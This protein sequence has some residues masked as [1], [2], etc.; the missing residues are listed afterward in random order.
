MVNSACGDVGACESF[1]DQGASDCA[2]MGRAGEFSMKNPLLSNDFE[3]QMSKH[4]AGVKFGKFSG[5]WIEGRSREGREERK[6]WAG[7]EPDRG[8]NRSKMRARAGVSRT[9]SSPVLSHRATLHP[10]PPGSA[11]QG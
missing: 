11:P 10:S 8:R 1:K 9:L 2:G 7:A 4:L 3:A 5:E 6:G